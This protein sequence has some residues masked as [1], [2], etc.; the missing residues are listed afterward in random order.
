MIAEVLIERQNRR[1]ETERGVDRVSR[2]Y[3]KNCISDRIRCIDVECLRISRVKNIVRNA[4]EESS[5]KH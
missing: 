5:V 3:F 2:G 4:I 1:K